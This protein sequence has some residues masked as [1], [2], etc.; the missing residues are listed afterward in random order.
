LHL[1]IISISS[2][3]DE[4]KNEVESGAFASA[5]EIVEVGILPDDGL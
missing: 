3:L 5:L 4:G 1:K 2:S